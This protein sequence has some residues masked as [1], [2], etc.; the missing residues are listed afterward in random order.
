MSIISLLS[1]FGQK[2]PYVAEMKAVILSINPHAR[3]IDISHE[4]EKFSIRIGAYVLASATPYFPPNTVHVAVVDP[5]VGTKR[6]PIIAETDCSI[7]VGPDNGLLM[8]AAH[9]E[10]INNV[11]R[12]DNSSYMLSEVSK[13][14]HGRDIFAPAAAHLATGIKPSEFGLVIHDYVFPEFAKLHMNHEEL[15]G[16][17]LHIDSYGNI[18]SNIS[19]EDLERVGFHE[20]DSLLVAFGSK[21]LKDAVNAALKYWIENLQDT[22]Y[23]LGSA[24]GPYPYPVIVRDFQSVIGKEVAIQITNIENRQPDILVACVG[25]GSNAVG[26]F[27]PF[28]QHR[29]IEFYGIE[30]GGV[31]TGPGKNAVRFGGNS[32]VGI[33]QG[34]KSFFLQDEDGQVLPTHSISA[35]LDYAG[36]GPE[37]AYLYASGKVVFKSVTDA[38]ALEAF[39]ILCREEGIIPALESAHAIAYA[40]KTAPK[41]SQDKIMVINLSG[42]G[43]KDI[44]ITAKT[45]DQENWFKFLSDEVKNG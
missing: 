27:F 29:Q 24:L 16:E 14:F 1:D 36:I 21:T 35:G 9:K 3:I 33:L 34:Y 13:T 26:L 6:R 18:I 12:I 8:L 23:L 2:D 44:F 15:V 32:K 20:G 25:G 11:F 17:V 28:L 45:L 5:G 38:E 31:G 7:Y 42:R 43:D 30:A 22:H 4:I 37:L 10:K 40:L 41:Y 19:A 39:Q